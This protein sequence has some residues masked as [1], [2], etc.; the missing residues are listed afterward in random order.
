MFH[1]MRR[2]DKALTEEQALEILSQKKE[3][4]LATVGDDGYPYA[5]PL[6]YVFQ[7]GAIYF[8]CAL[9]GHK[10]ENIAFNPKVSFCVTADST[11]IAEAFSTRFR[12]VVVFGRAEEALEEN[13]T[14]GL[15][16]LIRGLAWD[17]EQAGE[18]Y[19]RQDRDKTRVFKIKIEH[20]SGKAAHY[21]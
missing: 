2:K 8:H 3:G 20:L 16:A 11:I 12:S 18:T 1:K 10:L 14:Q 17:H 19:I 7:D 6:N 4:V 15:R 13:K 5:V 9:S 21:A